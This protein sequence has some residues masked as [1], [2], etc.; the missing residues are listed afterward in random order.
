[1][2]SSLFTIAIVFAIVFIFILLFR[3]FHKKGKHS[4]IAMQKELVADI[5]TRNKLEITEKETINNY[6]LAIDKINFMLLYINLSD[7]NGEAVLIDLWQIKTVKVSTEDN[8]VYEQKKG[9]SVLVDKRVSK[10]QIQVTL[11]NDQPIADLVLYEYKDALEDFIY[12]KK[13][14]DYWCHLIGKAVE[15]LRYASGQQSKYA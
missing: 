8:S 12:I 14:A 1:M 3:L 13:R 6:L 5:I 11:I 10:L 9:K 15:E 7:S 4:K 2:T